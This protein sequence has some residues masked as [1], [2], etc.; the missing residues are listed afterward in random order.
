MRQSIAIKELPGGVTEQA[1]H[2]LSAVPGLEQLLDNRSNRM[3]RTQ[4]QHCLGLGCELSEDGNV[5]FVS[6]P[7]TK[8]S[9]IK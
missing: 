7:L 4:Q 1:M 3:A 8:C 5:M 6:G 2:R 9:L